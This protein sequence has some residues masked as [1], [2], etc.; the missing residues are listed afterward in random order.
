MDKTN[1]EVDSLSL[2][3]HRVSDSKH[4]ISNTLVFLLFYHFTFKRITLSYRMPFSFVIGEIVYQPI[5]TG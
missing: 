2:R 1:I 4:Q 5:F 3:G